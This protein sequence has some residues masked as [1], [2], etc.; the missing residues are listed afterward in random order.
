MNIFA[1]ARKLRGFFF[2]NEQKKVIS[3]Q[4]FFNY[5]ETETEKRPSVKRG[6]SFAELVF[7][8]APKV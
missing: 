7:K 6:R 3:A 5:H 8:S 2:T 4:V 1:M